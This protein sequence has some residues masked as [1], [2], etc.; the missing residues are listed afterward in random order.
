MK[1]LANFYME[2][3]YCITTVNARKSYIV[4]SLCNFIYV[5]KKGRPW[6]DKVTAV[7][8]DPGYPNTIDGKHLSA[9]Y[10]LLKRLQNVGTY[11]THSP[12]IKAVLHPT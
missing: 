4:R 9:Q 11:A 3:L 2:N 8:H 7:R 10:R 12:Q 1:P 5:I 6:K